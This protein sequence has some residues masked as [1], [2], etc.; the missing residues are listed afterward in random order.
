[1]V[2]EGTELPAATQRPAFRE[3][4]NALIEKRQPDFRRSK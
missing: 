2:A 4:V 1:M 3:A